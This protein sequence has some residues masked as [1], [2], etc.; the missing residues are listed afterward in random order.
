MRRTIARGIYQGQYNYV[1]RWYDRGIPREQPFPLDTPIQ[2]LKDF[3]KRKLGQT[4]PPEKLG[5]FVR[6]VARYLKTRKGR[7][8]SQSERSHLKPWVTLFYRLSRWAITREMV[9]SAIGDW[10]LAGY[11]PRTIRHRVKTLAQVYRFYSPD[12]STPCD[13]V[14]LPSPPKPRPRSVSDALVRAV[15]LELRKHE[16]LG[17]LRDAKTRA[18]YLVDAT[19]G[20]RPIQHVRA[21]RGDVDLVRRIWTVRPAKGDQ[22]TLVYLNDDMVAAWALFIASDAWGDY[23][24]RSHARVLHNCGWPKGIRPYNLRHTVGLSLSELGIDLGDIQMHMGH[25]SP[26]TTRI[27]VPGVPQR[28]REA[29]AKL[30]GRLASPFAVEPFLPRSSTTNVAGRTSTLTD[31]LRDSEPS[32]SERKPTDDDPEK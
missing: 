9:Q 28:Q 20:Q 2:T 8:S 22:G 15:A 26:S 27:Y 30:D 5:S 14:K 3:R 23:D 21:Q 12:E 4:K 10:F 25:T 7:P 31:S 16:I 11:S 18:R 6:D 1:V 32:L 24:R 13:R 19:C 17:W 29:S